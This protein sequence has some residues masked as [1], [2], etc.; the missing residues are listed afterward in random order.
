MGFYKLRTSV[1]QNVLLDLYYTFIYSY[2]LYCNFVWGLTDCC[3]L[4]PLRLLQN[5]VI[6]IIA[7]EHYLA[8]T[9]LLFV[10]YRIIKDEN[11]HKYSL[12]LYMYQHRNFFKEN[13]NSLYSLR[14]PESIVPL[15]PR[16]STVGFNPTKGF[17][18]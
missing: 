16:L 2:L 14:N 1:P 17:K 8:H 18:L 3:S 6:R 15:F 11:L 5:M 12:G 7:G 4:T 9:D 10:K 13:M